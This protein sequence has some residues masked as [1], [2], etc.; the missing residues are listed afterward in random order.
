MCGLFHLFQHTSSVVPMWDSRA[1]GTAA[2]GI[3]SAGAIV[4]AHWLCCP[5]AG[6]LFLDQGSNPCPLRWR[7][8]LTHWTTRGFPHLAFEV[9]IKPVKSLWLKARGQ[10]SHWLDAKSGGG[11][12]GQRAAPDPSPHS[13]GKLVRQAW[14][15]PLA[16]S[17]RDGSGVS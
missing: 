15:I 9:H 12:I 3:Q 5:A 11:N 4:P 14:S 8:I 7:W 16:P 1:S 10:S 17:P 13:P 2:R 6:R